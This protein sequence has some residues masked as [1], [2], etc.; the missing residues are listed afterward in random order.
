MGKNKVRGIKLS[1]EDWYRRCP[2]L[3][4]DQTK[5]FAQKKFWFSCNKH[6]KFLAFP[7][8]QYRHPGCKK[9]SGNAKST[10]YWYAMFPDL[11]PN[12]T[13]YNVRTK[14]WFKCDKGHLF[15]TTVQIRK[16]HGCRYCSPSNPRVYIEALPIPEVAQS[17]TALGVTPKHSFFV[18]SFTS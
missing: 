7:N 18:L 15:D 11:E 5:I 10:E 4:P 16:T 1:D 9:C 14:V 13:I 2:N 6:G 12:Q 17:L 3:L 8:N